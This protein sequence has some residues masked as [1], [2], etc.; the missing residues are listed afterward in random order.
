MRTLHPIDPTRERVA[1]S[2]HAVRERVAAGG[3]VYVW[4][5][6]P[7]WRP[8]LPEALTGILGSEAFEALRREGR[9]VEDAFA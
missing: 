6:G 9:Y 4:G 8:P 3:V 1:A 2:G 7:R 5:D